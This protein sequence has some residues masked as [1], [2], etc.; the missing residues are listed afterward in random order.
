MDVCEKLFEKIEGSDKVLELIASEMPDMIF[1]PHPAIRW[2]YIRGSE[3]LVLDAKLPDNER[4]YGAKWKVPYAFPHVVVYAKMGAIEGTKASGNGTL[5]I[6]SDKERCLVLVRP[7]TFDFAAVRIT[8]RPVYY[9]AIL[10]IMYTPNPT[11][12]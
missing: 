3:D 12:Q 1:S 6:D 7:C 8:R 9:E 10:E 2:V 5:I 11:T 4:K